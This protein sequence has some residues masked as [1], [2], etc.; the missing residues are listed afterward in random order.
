MENDIPVV[1]VQLQEQF[2][3]AATREE[4]NSRTEH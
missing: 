3:L 2:R 4:E 1:Q